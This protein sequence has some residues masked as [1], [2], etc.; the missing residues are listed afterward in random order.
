MNTGNDDNVVD[1]R[2]TSIGDAEDDNNAMRLGVCINNVDNGNENDNA[3]TMSGLNFTKCAINKWSINKD[4]IMY[5]KQVLEQMNLEKV[6]V[7]EKARRNHYKQ[8]S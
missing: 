3:N 8:M 6:K 7:N 2:G 4:I 5:G 1:G